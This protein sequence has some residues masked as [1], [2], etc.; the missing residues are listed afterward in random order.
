MTSTTE[1]DLRSAGESAFDAPRGSELVRTIRIRSFRSIV[2]ATLAPGSLCAL[3]GEPQAGKSNV[4]AAVNTLLGEGVV[5]LSTDLSTTASGPIRIEATLGADQELSLE[6]SGLSVTRT[7]APPSVLYLPASERAAEL[8]VDEPEDQ[9][10]QEALGLMREALDE[11]GS[12]RS[13]SSGT[14]PAASLVDGVEACCVR[15][16]HGLVLLIEEPELYLRPQ[17]QRYL[18]RLL[19]TF[20]RSGNQVLYTTH[21][22]NLLNV[23]RLDELALVRLTDQGTSAIHPEPL[24]PG[25]DF[26]LLSEFDA[27][28]SELFLARAVVLVEG[29]TE[30]LALPF[31]FAT[32]G[33]D[34]DREGISIVECGGKANIVLFARVCLAS[35]VPFVVLHDRDTQDEV[36]NGVIREL[37]GDA[38]TVVASPDFEHVAGLRGRS[39]KPRRAW[40]R[41]ATM[42]RDELPATL[43]ETVELTVAL[44]RTE[45]ES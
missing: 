17:A 6:A 22:P 24:V 9:L 38:R 7:G 3:V 41:F 19:R 26:R 36:L 34:V 4:L 11:Q 42:R 45:G 44:A 15:G 21:S 40:R 12:G 27:Q 23:A 28:R 13:P 10:A 25:D 14:L 8:V 35:G 30:R 5:P 16:I 32:L 33:Y 1:R 2:D 37:A 43:R 18:Y 29:Q 31:A 39:H 20:A